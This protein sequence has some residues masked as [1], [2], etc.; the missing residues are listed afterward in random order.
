VRFFVAILAMILAVPSSGYYHFV[1]YTGPAGATQSVPLKFDVSALPNRTVMVLASDQGAGRVSQP[2]AFPALLNLIREACQTWNGVSTSDLRVAFGGMYSPA[3][4]QTTPGIDL[5]FEELDPNTQGYGSMITFGQTVNGPNGSFV[6]V[7]RSIVRLNRDLRIFATAS[8]GPSFAEAFFLT[9]THELGHALGLQHTFTASTMSTDVIRSTALS[10]PLDADDIAGISTLYPTSTLSERTGAISGRVLFQGTNEAVHLA[11]VVA[12]RPSGQA[13]S[14]LTDRD[15]RFRMAAIPPGAYQLYVHPLPLGRRDTPGDVTL[16]LDPNGNSVVGSGP[17]DTVF[18][19]DGGT[20]RDPRFASFLTVSAGATTENV[21]FAVRRRTAHRLTEQTTIYSYFGSTAVKPAYV[22]STGPNRTIVAT[23]RGGLVSNNTATAGLSVSFLGGTPLIPADGVRPYADS[24]LAIDIDSAST[25]ASSGP[26]HLVFSLPD[27]IYVRPNALIL[28]QTPP[29]ID[30]V[31]VNPENA[32]QAVVFGRNLRGDSRYY[33]D[34][35]RASVAGSDS[36]GNPILNIPPGI[37]GTRSAIAVYN[38][39]GM[40]SLFVQTAPTHLFETGDSGFLNLRTAAI[41]AGSESIVEIEGVGTSFTDG[42]TAVGFGTSDIQV[43]K[44][45]VPSS[46]RLLAN[47]WVAPEA[48]IGPVSVNITSG[49]QVVTAPLALTIRSAIASAP[50]LSSSIVNAVS[51]QSGIFPGALITV[52]GQNLANATFVI[53]DQAAEVTQ[54]T[55]S[56]VGLRVPANLTPGFALLRATANNEQAV[57]GL[58][59]EARPPVIA[60]V[61]GSSNVAVDGS[62]PVRAGDLVRITVTGL[63]DAGQAVAMSR[64]RVLIGGIEHPV[65]EVLPVGDSPASHRLNVILSSQVQSG[66][67]PLTVAIDGRT[68]APVNVV[69]GQ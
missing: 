59:I 12:I 17:F 64:L 40:N 69:V 32:R 22:D 6:S 11:S 27:D 31:T 14:A 66:S 21:Q 54:A 34:G 42:L 9:V 36:L 55:A 43:R 60:S 49:F 46:N 39:D 23:G 52:P 53:G 18:Y 67:Q 4:A 41:P 44:L 58:T 25:F 35:I 28:A 47:V 65:I 45:W 48:A 7:T 24:F 62:Q 10:R 20:T 61:T 13:V 51:G 2:E 3:T 37:R 56:G 16:P 1:R 68:S 26:R 63:A 29:Q 30:A 5:D 33:F 50:A 8:S 57:I 15:G 19:Q 38:S